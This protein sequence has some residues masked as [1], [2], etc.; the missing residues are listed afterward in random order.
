MPLANA[1]THSLSVCQTPSGVCGPYGSELMYQGSQL[2]D[3]NSGALTCFRGHIQQAS[4]GYFQA[5]CPQWCSDYTKSSRTRQAPTL[6][7]WQL[8]PSYFQFIYG[9]CRASDL[10]KKLLQTFPLMESMVSSRSS[11]NT[12]RPPGNSLF[13]RTSRWR[14]VHTQ[15]DPIYV[16]RHACVYGSHR[17]RRGWN[18]FWSRCHSR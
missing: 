8:E 16:H 6:T 11:Q 9:R 13:W 3:R 7:G 1:R 14:Q 4:A 5:S 17:G 2:H 18:C 15:C 12:I 10:S